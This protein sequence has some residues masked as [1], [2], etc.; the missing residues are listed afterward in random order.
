MRDYDNKIRKKEEENFMK[1]FKFEDIEYRKIVQKEPKGEHQFVRS[2]QKDTRDDFIS[3]GFGFK[4]QKV[5]NESEKRKEIEHYLEEAKLKADKI[6]KEAKKR[7]FEEGKSIGLEEGRKIVDPLIES[8][9]KG[10]IEIS[11]LK[12]DIYKAMESEILELVFAISEKVIHKEVTTDKGIVLNTIRAA[13][14]SII[15][16][17]EIT[18]KVNPEDLEVA[19]EIKTDLA[20][21]NGFKK[22]TIEGDTSVGRGG[23]VVETNLGS[24]DARI[25]QQIDEIEHALK[26]V[27]G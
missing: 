27:R 20:I 8:L 10:L 3:G 2:K 18:I 26:D 1:P 5:D 7:G 13:V 15:G 4:F 12:E 9:R 24:I 11:R 16:K 19:R 21:S 23:C 17:D 6:K 25:E 22:I 14:H